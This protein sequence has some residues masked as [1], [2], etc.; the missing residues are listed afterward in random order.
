MKKFFIIFKINIKK[1][2]L[3][4]FLFLISTILFFPEHSLRLE[5]VNNMVK[6]LGFE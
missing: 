2:L 3:I 5:K 4:S 6:N 1:I